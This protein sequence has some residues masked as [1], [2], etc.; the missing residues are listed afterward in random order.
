MTQTLDVHGRASIP[1]D[2]EVAA[3]RPTASGVFVAWVYLDER[4][5]YDTDVVTSIAWTSAIPGFIG[6]IAGSYFIPVEWA[7]RTW[8]KLLL[9]VPVAGLVVLT[10][11]LRSYFLR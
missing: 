7:E 4:A 2:Q 6:A 3:D 11:S 1:R 9:I 10:I 5:S 8:T